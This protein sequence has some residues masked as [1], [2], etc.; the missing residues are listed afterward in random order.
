MGGIASGVP[1][2][3]LGDSYRTGFGTKY[4]NLDSALMKIAVDYNSLNAA[5]NGDTYRNGSCY[6]LKMGIN[7]QH[8]LDR[9]YEASNWVTFI[10]RK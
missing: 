10:N 2:E 5:M 8:I 6:A 4:A 9:I 1:S 3:M 7:K